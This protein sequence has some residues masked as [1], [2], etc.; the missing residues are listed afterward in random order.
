MQTKGQSA[1]LFALILLL[2][3]GAVFMAM[4]GALPGMKSGADELGADIA[5]YLESSQEVQN[6]VWIAQN[7]VAAWINQQR[8]VPNKHAVEQHGADAWAATNCYNNNGTFQIYS[9]GFDH[10]FLC[11]EQDGTIRDVIFAKDGNTKNFHMKSAFTPKDG[12]LSRVVQWLKNKGAVRAT[13]PQ[14]AVFYIDGMIP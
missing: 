11:A 3:L 9:V 1:V 14:D 10:H 12:V 2:V 13:V 7:S 8:F 5:N 4:A 6:E